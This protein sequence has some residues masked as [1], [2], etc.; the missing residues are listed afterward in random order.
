MDHE[1]AN[2]VHPLL[3]AYRQGYFPMA[4]PDARGRDRIHWYNP[5]PRGI[6]PLEPKGPGVEGFHIPRRLRDRVRSGRFQITSDTAFREV[7]TA[8]SEP[9]PDEPKSWIDSQII[10]AYTALH[11]AGHAS[12]IE[13]WLP[14]ES[15][16]PVL[17]GG[18][19]GV[20]I[21]AAFFA[22]SK[23]SRPALGGTD[24][25]KVCLVH[26]VLHLRRRGYT[27][28]DTQFWNPHIAQFGCVEI[29]RR[30]YLRRLQ[31][32]I[33]RPVAWEPFGPVPPV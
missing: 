6:I 2:A 11:Q 30:E 12:S 19:Y 20:R 28:L 14:D 17:V 27:L 9:R 1:P 15:G 21:G 33:D 29:P 10:E 24:A 16:K 23:F 8:C 5:D 22:E 18:L 26:L 32:A 31:A 3:S 7:I 4:D 13:A 25:S